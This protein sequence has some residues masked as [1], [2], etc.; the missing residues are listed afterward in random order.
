MRLRPQKQIEQEIEVNNNEDDVIET[1]DD[2]P[3]I[4]A[5]KKNT[6]I[7]VV[8][9]IVLV[10]IC[11]YVFIKD[12][13]N[14]EVK[15]EPVNNSNNT[16]LNSTITVAEPLAPKQ[17]DQSMFDL[18]EI[19]KKEK[20]EN[21]NLLEK[22][23]KP[24][25]PDLP[26]LPKEDISNDALKSAVA[27]IEDKN[28]LESDSNKTDAKTSID[29]KE[30]SVELLDKEKLA[31]F[32]LKDQK[33]QEL[34]AKIKEQEELSA[35]EKQAIIDDY[36]KKEV[37]RKKS[38]EKQDLL[39]KK[40]EEESAELNFDP[41]Y[42]PIVVFSDR[43]DISPSQGVGQE[44]NIIALKD[45]ADQ[46]K[47]AETTVD[48]SLIQNRVRTIAQGK[49]ITAVLETSINTEFPGAVRGIITRDVYGEAGKEVLIP[50]GS[51]LYGG[52]S[53]EVRR[54][55]GRVDISWT[56]LLLPNG[57]SLNISLNSADQFGRAGI[58]GDVDNRYTSLVANSLLTSVLAVAGT[59][60]AQSI[61]G[62]SAQTSTTLNVNQ[63][64]TTTYGNAGNQALYDVTRTIIDIVGNIVKN[65]MDLNPVIRVPQGT[66]M[67]VIVNADILI[68][69]IK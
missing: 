36:N 49:L 21:I 69:K 17:E 23:A 58:P 64:T 48:V 55:Q 3:S 47:S 16:E 37:E 6:V 22:Q 7:I 45:Q 1:K 26:E 5:N 54:G 12:I 51:R 43:R 8:A 31:E 53:A 29:I 4:S 10:I 18:Q 28:S 35:K 13:K 27:K 33:I 59:A 9:S 20:S 68:P 14:Q 11:Y 61:M 25:I 40:K 30:P 38:Q 66:R 24:Q 44:R 41:R 15:I 67:T 56:R 60:A 19:D 46:I 2:G 32:K 65:T 57:I 34:E 63:G 39:N 50:K 62:G 52:Y 42:A